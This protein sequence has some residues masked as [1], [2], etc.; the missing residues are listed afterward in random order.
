[1]LKSDSECAGMGGI[2]KPER[3]VCI[4]PL[5]PSRDFGKENCRN[6]VRGAHSGKEYLPVVS[7]FL[8]EKDILAE[9]CIIPLKD[10]MELK[11]FD[12]ES[13][14]EQEIYWE[15]EAISKEAAA[16]KVWLGNADERDWQRGVMRNVGP[17]NEKI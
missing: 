15:V 8:K 17:V 13:W 10:S 6:I 3:E 5:D 4:I 7:R 2:W 12:A 1:M 16:R 14:A 9:S 11:K